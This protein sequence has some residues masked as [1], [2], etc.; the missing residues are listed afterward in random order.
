L[1]ELLHEQ[2]RLYNEA[3]ATLAGLEHG[4]DPSLR[5][6]VVQI[7]VAQEDVVGRLERARARIV[8]GQQAGARAI[9]AA[10]SREPAE[11]LWQPQAYRVA[12]TTAAT[13]PAPE[14]V[15]AAPTPQRLPRRPLRL[16][17]ARRAAQATSQG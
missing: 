7:A 16:L 6:R 12:A 5:D 17:S 13:G 15:V 14:P 3:A 2:P 10:L 9:S 4:R 11:L 8:A 1:R